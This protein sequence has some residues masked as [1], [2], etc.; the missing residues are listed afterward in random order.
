MTQRDQTFDIMKGI[1][2]L[3]V[4][5]AHFFSWNHPILGRSITSFHMPMFFIVAGY[6]SKSYTNKED[7]IKNIK[8]FARRLLPAFA[9]TQVILI[10]WAILMAFTKDESWNQVI[11][12]TL[13]LF[14][15]DP[16]GPMTPWGKLT[17]GVIWFI[18]ALFVSKTLLLFISLLKY[19]AL[20]VS[21]LLAIIAIVV[22]KIFPYSIWCLSL[23]YTAL[24]FVTLGWWI[25]TH[26]IPLWLKIVCIICWVIA[27]FYSE[28]GMYDIEWGC[29]PLDVLGA[30][31]GTYCLYLISRLIK[32]Y[33]K[34]LAGLLAVLGIWSLAIMCFHN[35][36]LDCHLG[37]HLMALFPFDFPVW[38]KY[39]FRYLLT[40]ALAG[41]AIKLPITKKIFS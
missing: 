8:K 25:K 32:D 30:C 33:A 41:I 35:I 23:A 2:I 5:T 29:Y 16:H 10:L 3:L 1:G 34:P 6:F 26:P 24:P 17:L 11:R 22:H 12:Q 9:F 7:S 18:F 20:P 36:E 4:I 19:W 37:N 28:L 31:G 21:F 40:I 39:V 27:I 15:A 14:W 13:S 38:G